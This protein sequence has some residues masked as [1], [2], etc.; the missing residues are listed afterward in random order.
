MIPAFSDGLNIQISNY[1]RQYHFDCIG[2]EVL[3]KKWYC[4][5]C[6][7]KSAPGRASKRGRKGAELDG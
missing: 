1:M 6:R 7:K 3:P 5:A 2:L 4:N